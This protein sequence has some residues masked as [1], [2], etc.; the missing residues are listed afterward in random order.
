MTVPEA[1]TGRGGDK[2]LAPLAICHRAEMFAVR[3]LRDA[4]GSI[5]FQTGVKKEI[6]LKQ[7]PCVPRASSE[8]W[9]FRSPC[10]EFTRP[11]SLFGRPVALST[12]AG[13]CV[14]AVADRSHQGRVWLDKA[15]L[16]VPAVERWWRRSLSRTP[17]CLFAM[18]RD[19]SAHGKGIPWRR[20][21]RRGGLAALGE[22][23]D[24][25]GAPRTGARP[26]HAGKAAGE[27]GSPG[28][29]THRVQERHGR[30][31]VMRDVPSWS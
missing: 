12:A 28:K 18:A 13:A 5:R 6:A 19:A 30:Q 4:G 15:P 10:C 11:L 17:K 25:H 7:R 29:T 2:R 3:P 9:S 8:S 21:A 24:G 16:P 1:Q 14:L 26:S 23:S 22:R 31:V 20:T 27:Q